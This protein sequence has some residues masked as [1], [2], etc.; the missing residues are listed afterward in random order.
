MLGYELQRLNEGLGLEN[1]G[2][3]QLVLTVYFKTDEKNNLTFEINPKSLEEYLSKSL[4]QLGLEFN[5]VDLEKLNLV[6]HNL[7]D[8]KFSKPEPRGK[9]FYVTIPVKLRGNIIYAE[10]VKFDTQT[11]EFLESSESSKGKPYYKFLLNEYL[12]SGIL[13]Q[14]KKAN[15]KNYTKNPEK[16]K[17][18]IKFLWNDWKKFFFNEKDKTVLRILKEG[19]LI[20]LLPSKYQ[21]DAAKKELSEAYEEVHKGYNTPDDG[22][23]FSRD[24]AA[25]IINYKNDPNILNTLT[26]VNPNYVSFSKKPSKQRNLLFY[27]IFIHKYETQP[28]K[29]YQGIVANLY[30]GYSDLLHSN[31]KEIEN[32]LV[33]G[34]KKQNQKSEVILYAHV[35]ATR[36]DEIYSK[37]SAIKKTQLD[38]RK[39]DNKILNWLLESLFLEKTN[40]DYNIRFYVEAANDFLVF[41][42]ESFFDEAKRFLNKRV[43]SEKGRYID[44]IKNNEI[45]DIEDFF[46]K[47]DF[48]LL[49]KYL[50][51]N[52]GDGMQQPKYMKTEEYFAYLIGTSVGKY[53][54]LLK[55]SE[56]L[57][58]SAYDLIS[59][60]KY[61]YEKLKF[62]FEK[63]GRA[64][65]IKK[66]EDK[67]EEM[68]KYFNT[69]SNEI[70]DTL[71]KLPASEEIKDKDLAF[72]FYLGVFKEL[73][74]N[75]K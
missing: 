36:L 11:E 8:F 17:E 25:F 30:E 41:E 32:I 67:Q 7:L 18:L 57:D 55:K 34:L 44:A 75:G 63:L 53:L 49:F 9:L 73:G 39:N 48:Y 16:I 47:A 5:K 3:P 2:M 19:M 65:G 60:D 64:I 28:V 4:E 66:L 51:H 43:I 42:N 70:D 61:D 21:T 22:K 29:Y 45:K 14:D 69:I 20:L 27:Y 33:V 74:N 40:K 52:S 62:V 10:G 26:N 38:K 31:S 6:P 71:G 37:I 1:L 58:N 35:P 56:N 24:D 59:Y 13:V 50:M 72:F 23:F 68:E 54:Q 15:S 46:S 12:E